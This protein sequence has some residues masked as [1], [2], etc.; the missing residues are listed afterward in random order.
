M[1][2]IIPVREGKVQRSFNINGLPQDGYDDIVL[3]KLNECTKYIRVMESSLAN[4][5]CAKIKSDQRSGL[6]SV[7][8]CVHLS[9]LKYRVNNIIISSI[10]LIM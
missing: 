9:Q 8:P 7:L 3:L 5:K 2:C 1:Y 10:R 4:L 6:S